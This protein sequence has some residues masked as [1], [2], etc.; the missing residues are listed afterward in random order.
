MSEENVEI[1]RSILAAWETGDFS[2]A[3][4]ADPEIHFIPGGLESDTH[5]IEALS[6][7]WRESLDSWDEFATVPEEFFDAE[8]GR[9]LVLVRFR[10]KG[11]GSGA[12]I[13]DFEGAQLFSVR[14]GKVVRLALFTDRS[15]ALEAAG[16]SE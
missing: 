9:V 16:L 10:G 5:G 13:V 15:E 2:A 8:D 3:T 4:W 11:K 6:K 1:V 7:Q 14:D 12:P